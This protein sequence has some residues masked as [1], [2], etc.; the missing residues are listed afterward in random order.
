M[1]I[2][3]VTFEEFSQIFP[4]PFHIFGSGEF[5]KMNIE[6]ADQVFCLVF[7]DRKYR[8]GLTGGLRNNGF[9]T[10]FSAPHGGFVYL[11]EDIKIQHIDEAIEVLIQWCKKKKMSFISFTLPPDLYNRNFLT[12]QVNSLFRNGFYIKDLELNHS[13]NLSNF[14]DDYISFIWQN[15]RKNLKI[16]LSKNLIFKKCDSTEDKETAYEIIKCNRKVRGFPLNM[17]MEE[18]KKTMN[19]IPA[20]FFLVYNDE[21]TPIASAIVFHVAKDIVQVIYWGDIPD[22]SLL[23]TMNFLTFHVFEYYKNLGIKIVD[24]GQ[25]TVDSIPNQGLCDFKE[26]IGCDV[27]EKRTFRLE[28]K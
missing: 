4:S 21:N 9:F 6:K 19:V 25:S 1:E 11:K 3:E 7:K 22:Y 12:K 28:L 14:N 2:Q 5:A 10:P 13:F 16:A 20:D 8:F 15:A 24:I 23:K 27:S 26:S 18:V 17:T